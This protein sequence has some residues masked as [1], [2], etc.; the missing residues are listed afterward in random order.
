MLSVYLI[1][2]VDD[3]KEAPVGIQ[4]AKQVLGPRGDSENVFANV[5]SVTTNEE[6]F[7]LLNE[8][9][10]QQKSYPISTPVVFVIDAHGNEEGISLPNNSTIKWESLSDY[11]RQINRLSR[12]NLILILGSCHGAYGLKMVEFGEPAPFLCMFGPKAKINSYILQCFY[13][14]FFTKLLD[15]KILDLFIRSIMDEYREYIYF[16][17]ASGMLKEAYKVYYK[18]TNRPRILQHRKKMMKKLIKAKHISADIKDQKLK[19]L[20]NEHKYNKTMFELFSAKFFMFD[21]IPENIQR[22][23]YFNFESIVLNND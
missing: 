3:S 18:K 23:E 22:F 10:F 2:G 8:A 15:N 20:K 14:D 21:E 12:M 6:L 17:T 4:A 9:Y 5:V 13:R 11:F 1:S 7:S 16:S 19:L